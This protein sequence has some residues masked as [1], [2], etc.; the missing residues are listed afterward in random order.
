MLQYIR[1]LF[2][3]GTATTTST[4]NWMLLAFLHYPECQ[5]KIHAEIEAT[6]GMINLG[7]FLVH[8]VLIEKIHLLFELNTILVHAS[9]VKNIAN[10]QL[11]FY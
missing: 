1:D 3:A 8:C 6:L 7:Y 5:D 4:L 10:S 11:Q 2:E 9:K